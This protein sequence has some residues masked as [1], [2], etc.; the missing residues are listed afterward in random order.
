MTVSTN[1]RVRRGLRCWRLLQASAWIVIPVGI[2]A[3]VWGPLLERYHVSNVTPTPTMISRARLQPS[4]HVLDDLW[5]RS[6]LQNTLQV[7][8]SQVVR[9]ANSYLRGLVEIPGYSRLSF[10]LPIRLSEVESA[11][12]GLQL[13]IAG[14]A[15]PG[16]LLRAYR[17]TGRNDFLLAAKEYIVAWNSFEKQ[18]W[19]PPGLMW[20]DNALSSRVGVLARFWEMYRRRQ[21]FDPN[22]ARA[23]LQL[24]NRSV[25]LLARRDQFTFATNHGVMQNIALIQASIAFPSIPGVKEYR[26]LAISRLQQQFEFYIDHE[27]VIL[28]HSPE[29]QGFGVA[30]LADAMRC[31]TVAGVS[32]PSGWWQ[33]Y[34]QAKEVYAEFRRPDG[35]LP[36]FGDTDWAPDANGPAI[37]AVDKKGYAMPLRWAPKS[38]RPATGE[39]LYPI[40]GYSVWWQ[41]LAYW[42]DV[43]RL[44]QTAIT[45]SYF[46]RHGHKHADEMSVAFWARGQNWWGNVGYWPY[47][48]RGRDQAESWSGSNAPH[49]AGE[50]TDSRRETRAIRKSKSE[51]QHLRFLEL[52]RKVGSSVLHRQVISLTPDV[53]VVLDDFNSSGLVEE[54]WTTSPAVHIEDSNHRHSYCLQSL[55]QNSSLSVHFLGAN[56]VSVRRYMGSFQPFA[57]WAVVRS[58]PTPTESFLLE[59]PDKSAWMANIWR[60]VGPASDSCLVS[61]S[62]VMTSWANDQ[63]WS[64]SFPLGWGIRKITRDDNRIRVWRER[65]QSSPLVV[66]LDALPSPMKERAQINRAFARAAAEYPRYRIE[67][68]FR[69][70]LSGLLFAIFVVEVTGL[71]VVKRFLS[72]RAVL[73]LLALHCCAW[74]GGGI[75]LYLRYFGPF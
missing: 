44:A 43:S 55:S 41:G 34:I 36:V 50:L 70:K 17:M 58:Q 71:W 64:L 28:E 14:F 31:L 66:T 35:S 52:E 69:E 20:N 15:I 38:W 63:S 62:P 9:V 1:V 7:D 23:V 61:P 46:P 24:V 40:A 32:I 10:G 37:T 68:G 74:I 30:L 45:W 19:L 21:D 59:S 26:M 53:W 67:V 13:P 2:F 42:P 25:Q 27:G 11:P 73:M 51:D 22:V 65:G 56:G 8:N 5:N 18:T 29:Y 75:W 6:P 54:T 39:A 33:K 16:I 72:G 49:L 48:I 57:G 12:P 3:M 47:D 4:D 60:V